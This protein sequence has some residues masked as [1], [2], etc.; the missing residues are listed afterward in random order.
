MKYWGPSA[1]MG[2][3]KSPS[4]VQHCVATIDDERYS[5]YV[6]LRHET[7]PFSP[8]VLSH[9]ESNKENDVPSGVPRPLNSTPL[10]YVI[11]SSLAVF[12]YMYTS[13]REALR[14][15]CPILEDLSP[16]LGTVPVGAALTSFVDGAD[17]SVL[18]KIWGRM[19]M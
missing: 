7:A 13:S 8:T 6:S 18:P 2:I 11:F 16:V 14:E 12:I 10:R 5:F 3:S 1:P 4:G 17:V 15:F 9:L 19:V